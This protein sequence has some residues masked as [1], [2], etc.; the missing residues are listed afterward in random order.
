[1]TVELIE[2][3]YNKFFYKPH[4]YL[5]G[6]ASM[7]LYIYLKHKNVFKQNI[8]IPS[9]ICHSIPFTIIYSNNYPIFYDINLESG[10]ACL[11]SVKNKLLSEN[12][13]AILI[14]NMYGNLCIERESILELAKEQREILII[15]DCAASLGADM[16]YLLYSGDAAIFSFGTNKHLDLGMGGLLASNEKINVKE[17]LGETTSSSQA[18]LYNI[19]IFDDLYKTIFYSRYYYELLPLFNKTIDFFKNNY[20]YNIEWNNELIDM[21]DKKLLEVE[22]NKQLSL[23]KVE[24]LNNKIDFNTPY[25][26]KYE[27]NRGSNPWR[28]NIFINDTNLKEKII[29]KALAKRILVNKW[30]KS[31]EPLFNL[32]ASENANM[33]GEKI[34]NF[35][36][37][38][39][40]W[41][42]LDNIINIINDK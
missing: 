18:A 25:I 12:I 33:F 15:D 16:D 14:P 29:S 28:Y 27:F 2:D 26:T 35:N 3:R 32:P 38:K 21:F 20:V 19:N 13:R 11:N 34:L 8:L 17:I 40:N 4:K 42:D 36:H 7:G 9:N 30:Y 39:S 6:S 23:D 22:K 41:D 37:T 5:L 10:N 1:M 24:Y 31:I